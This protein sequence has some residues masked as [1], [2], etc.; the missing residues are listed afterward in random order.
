M[1]EEKYLW[2]IFV[3]NQVAQHP[4]TLPSTGEFP[5]LRVSEAGRAQ[6]STSEAKIATESFRILTPGA[7]QKA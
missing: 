4:N 6:S 1:N 5:M 3:A 2:F 7:K